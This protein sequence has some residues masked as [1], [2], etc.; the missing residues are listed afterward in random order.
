MVSKDTTRVELGM[1]T[2]DWLSMD[3]S[4]LGSRTLDNLLE[5]DR[6]RRLCGHISGH[7]AGRMKDCKEVVSRITRALVEK[8]EA[9]GD[10]VGL[11]ANNLKLTEEV[12]SLKRRLA[13]K[14]KERDEMMRLITEL[15][16]EV[17][18]LKSGMGPFPARQPL[19]GSPPDAGMDVSDGPA[20]GPGGSAVGG[21]AGGAVS[22]PR[23]SLSGYSAGELQGSGRRGGRPRGGE[24]ATRGVSARA[25]GDRSG[26][27]GVEDG[28]FPPPGGSFAEKTKRG[29]RVIENRQLVPPRGLRAGEYVA[30]GSGRGVRGGA[31]VSGSPA[32][33]TSGVTVDR[34][35]TVG[36]RGGGQTRCSAPAS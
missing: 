19:P 21:G 31:S 28:R 30:G 4:S 22:P 7:V 5:L 3:V 17:R 25:A 18:A 32:R 29:P 24:F 16:R 12:R 9:S 26:R 11:N 1:S 20:A 8:L 15:Q 23:S 13:A 35:A 2:D 10:V 14:E 27:K 33:V 6:Q 36:A 34:G